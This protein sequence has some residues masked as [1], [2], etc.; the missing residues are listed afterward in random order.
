MDLNTLIYGLGISGLFASRAFI[1]AFISS[2]VL[3]FGGNFPLLKEVDILQNIGGG[4]PSWFTNGYVITAL[5]VL[6]LLEIGATKIPEAEEALESVNKYLK[7][8][9]VAATYF[10][11]LSTADQGYI[12]ENLLVMQAGF[13]SSVWGLLSTANT[14]FF[15]SLR[16]SILEFL[17]EADQDDDLGLRKLISWAEDGWAIFG[18]FWL[19]IYPVVVLIILGIVLGSALLIK[20]YYEYKEEKSRIDCGECDATNYPSATECQNCHAPVSA[21]VKIGMF[22]Q[23][24]SEPA[25]DLGSH[26]L[27]LVEKKRCPACATRLGERDPHQTCKSCGHELFKDEAFSRDYLG[28]VAGRVPVVL[29]ISLGLSFIPFLG[30]II[31]IIIY[32]IQLVAPFRR[33]I[34]L[35]RSFFIKWMIRFLFLFLIVLQVIPGAGGVAV[36][37]MAFISYRTYRGSFLKGLNLSV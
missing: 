26:K 16:S 12:E 29:I 1:P 2:V 34:P 7:T 8:G 6:S 15:A 22:G 23:S 24:K 11:F 4:E 17:F 37:I 19:I 36:P 30:L 21:P 20:K 25:G 14:Y 28:K 13:M 18:F 33:Y 32:R 35:H 9:M 5:G 31:G 3:R 10:G 27:R